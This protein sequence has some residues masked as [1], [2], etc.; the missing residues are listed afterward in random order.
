MIS[1]GK[2]K[3]HIKIVTI[4]DIKR[5]FRDTTGIIA[6]C[7]IAGFGLALFLIPYKAS[8]GGAGGIAQVFF[9]IYDFK[10]GVVMLIINIPLFIIG[11]LIFGKTFG[12]K[13]LIGMFFLSIFTDFFSSKTFTEL[14]VLQDFIYRINEQTV[15]FTD[16]YLLG[17]IAGSLLLGAGVGIVVKFNGSTGG[18]DIPALLIRKYFGLSMGTSFLLIDSVIITIVGII[19]KDPNLIL[20][21][22]LALYVTTKATDYVIEGM[23]YTKGVFII[24]EKMDKIKEYILVELNRG[25]T[26]LQGK[27]GFTGEEKNVLYI[28][29]HQRELPKLK[30][31]VK[32]LDKRAFMVVNDAYETNGEGFK[33]WDD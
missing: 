26:I 32:E 15:S 28:A 5:F 17:V 10:P 19:F 12:I 11:M 18:S 21:G 24:S 33:E 30:E 8:P 31:K 7:A 1:A 13:T 27:G 3:N 4:K 23:S 16:I 14:N 20:W 22:F 29:I 9:Y 25:C 6:G 2:L